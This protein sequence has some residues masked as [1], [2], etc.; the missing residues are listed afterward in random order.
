MGQWLH[1]VQRVSP[2]RS[3]DVIESIVKELYNRTVRPHLPSKIGVFNNVAA[4]RIA[5]FDATDEFPEYEAELID[6]VRE[7]VG[8]GDD[9]VV[10]GGGHGI[11]SVVATRRAGPDGRVTAFEPAR[12]RVEQ[13]QETVA[14]NGVADR[15]R[16]R[17]ALV[18]PGV[19]VDGDGS[20]AERVSPANLPDCDVL[21]LDCEGAEAKI[22][23]N[24]EIR[25]SSIVVETHD[26]FGTPEAETRDALTDLG[27][28]VI[29]RAEDEPERGIFV[30]T[31]T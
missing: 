18:G 17:W 31:A 19:K 21:V 13:M 24:I 27:Y 14:L 6:A 22:L 16:T 28:E 7:T 26:C 2:L 12:E 3:S 23:R 1:A 30:L 25:P 15:V 4:R 29:E 11:S 20:N 5:L 9:V 10:I 8:R